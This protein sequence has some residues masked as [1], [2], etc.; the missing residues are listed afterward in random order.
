[1]KKYQN[2]RLMGEIT[3]KNRFIFLCVLF[4]ITLTTGC[5]LS[6]NNAKENNETYPEETVARFVEGCSDCDAEVVLNCINPK[7]SKGIKTASNL[8]GKVI[9]V[10]IADIA[11]IIPMVKVLLEPYA[12]G[13]ITN[14]SVESMDTEYDN[15]TAAKVEA[16]IIGENNSKTQKVSAIF[17]LEKIDD[18]WYIMNISD[19]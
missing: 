6:A 15:D 16:V 1:M 9:G 19:N 2:L 4:I 5:N 11:N 17:S 8:V 13:E 3:L 14:L 18:K 12:D 7:I 10:E